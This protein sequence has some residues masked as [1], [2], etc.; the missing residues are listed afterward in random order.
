MV[1]QGQ[2][3][4]VES[5]IEQKRQEGVESN[6]RRCPAET[7]HIKEKGHLSVF[8]FVVKRPKMLSSFKNQ[9]LKH[10]IS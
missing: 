7:C 9:E 4:M 6:N 2:S 10:V 3:G 5:N 1:E 8:L